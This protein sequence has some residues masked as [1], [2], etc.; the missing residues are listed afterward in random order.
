[1]N[2]ED[3]ISQCI[4]MWLYIGELKTRLQRE[5]EVLEMLL[6]PENV[7][8]ELKRLIKENEGLKTKVNGS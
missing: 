3:K 7:D 2:D 5:N 1:M 6:N 4:K 8:S